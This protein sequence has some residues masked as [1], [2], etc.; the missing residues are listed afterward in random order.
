MRATVWICS[1]LD[2]LGR[3]SHSAVVFKKDRFNVTPTNGWAFSYYT[4]N[5][6]ILGLHNSHDDRRKIKKR[7]TLAQKA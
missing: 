1:K 2:L 3:S 7:A 4:I 6:A 5:K